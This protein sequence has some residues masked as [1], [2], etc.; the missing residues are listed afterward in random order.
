[1]FLQDQYDTYAMHGSKMMLSRL[2]LAHYV[3]TEET[4]CEKT[5]DRLL[6][7]PELH[8]REL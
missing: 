8:T 6:Y 4:T 7:A 1:M 5:T 2:I 3:V